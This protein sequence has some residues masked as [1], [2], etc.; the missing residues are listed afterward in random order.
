MCPCPSLRS[1]DQRSR[2]SFIC[3][4]PPE[5]VRRFAASAPPP[6]HNPSSNM[7]TVDFTG[8]WQLNRSKSDD[9]SVI[10]EAQEVPY[11]LRLAASKFSPKINLVQEGLSITEN[12]P[13]PIGG[14]KTRVIVCDG[15]EREIKSDQGLA[16]LTVAKFTE[17]GKLSI[18][19]RNEAKGVVISATWE[20]QGTEQIKIIHVKT[21]KVDKVVRLYFDRA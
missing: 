7:A 11:L 4:S 15:E 20:I 2:R 3:A 9:N 18:V 13:L 14:F 8:D 16:F 17:D 5:D 10:L 21:P 12:I 1:G 6:P 19:N